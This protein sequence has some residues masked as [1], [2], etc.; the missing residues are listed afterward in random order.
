[1]AMLDNPWYKCPEPE[2]LWCCGLV[3]IN[4]SYLII[5]LIS[6]K[7]KSTRHRPYTDRIIS[8]TKPVET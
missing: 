3:S 2:F 1:M 7:K 5:E 6:K 4:V 8:I